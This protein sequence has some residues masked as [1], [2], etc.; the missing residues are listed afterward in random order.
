M[1]KVVEGIVCELPQC[2]VCHAKAVFSLLAVFASVI[3]DNFR[4]FFIYQ[5]VSVLVNGLFFF[6]R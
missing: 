1:V 4:S 2:L 6:A 5:I 3:V